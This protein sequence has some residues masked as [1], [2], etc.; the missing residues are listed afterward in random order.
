MPIMNTKNTNQPSLVPE[1]PVIYD[2]ETW[3]MIGH[4]MAFCLGDA[5]HDGRHMAITEF[6]DEKLIVTWALFTGKDE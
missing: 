5:D 3:L 2:C 6:H 1:K 4:E